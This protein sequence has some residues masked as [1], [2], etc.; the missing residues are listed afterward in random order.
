MKLTPFQIA[1]ALHRSDPDNDPWEEVLS[2]HLIAGYVIS[3]PDVFLLFRPVDSRA[4]PLEY[5]CAWVTYSTP[6]Q[7]H[8]YLAAGKLSQFEQWIPPIYDRISAV[9]KNSLR[10]WDRADMRGKIVS[11]DHGQQAEK[12]QHGSNQCSDRGVAG[13][14][15]RS[16]TT[17]ETGPAHRDSLFQD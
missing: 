2:A 13:A 8:I 16:S 3:T 1:R 12:S 15:S 14:D 5:D 7:W 10:V 17:S 9:R 11:L 4:N 6:D